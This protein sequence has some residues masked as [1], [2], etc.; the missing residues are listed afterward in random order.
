MSCTR[1]A[2]LVVLA[3]LVVAVAFGEPENQDPPWEGEYCMYPYY[4]DIDTYS[5]PVNLRN[6]TTCG[7]L[8][9]YS[10]T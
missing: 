10:Q 9:Y 1:I 8:N 4:I 2:M 3:I 7:Y 5:L 6:F